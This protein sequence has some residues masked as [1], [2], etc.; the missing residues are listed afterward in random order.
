MKKRTFLYVVCFFLLVIM[1]LAKTFA[2]S[3][4][5]FSLDNIPPF[6]DVPYVI[7]NDN[8]PEF[9]EE[10][11]HTE[12]FAFYS[13]LDSLGRCGEAFSNI[14]INLIP[15]EER[16]SIS[17]VKPTG[18]HTIKYDFI[19]GKYLYNRCHLI[20]YQLTGENANKKNLMTCTRSMN[21]DGMLPFENM[22]A[23]YIKETNNHVLYRVRPIYEGD[24]LLAS[25]VTMEARS[26]E[27]N[28][29]GIEFYVFI[30]NAQKGVT[31]D[32]KTGDATENK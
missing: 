20:G 14:G 10:D 8:V 27:D 11:F 22:V 18:W 30:Y 2:N 16:G 15:T 31:I 21:V 28:G 5:S 4:S 19:E 7:I 17:S 3:T 29:E 12:S 6:E 26:V 1:H 24:N 13:E 23:D 9:K 32:Y 25:G